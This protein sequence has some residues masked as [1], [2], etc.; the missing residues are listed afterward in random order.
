MFLVTTYEQILSTGDGKSLVFAMTLKL[1]PKFWRNQEI[2]EKFLKR[3]EQVKPDL[4][5]FFIYFFFFLFKNFA[6]PSPD[7]PPYNLT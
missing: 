6:I 5:R 2:H 3:Y 7:Y 1:I 4:Y